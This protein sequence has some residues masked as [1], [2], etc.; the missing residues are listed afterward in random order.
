MRDYLY[1]W[2]EPDK[3]RLVASGIE[4]RDIVPEL[5]SADGVVLLRHK[6]ADADTDSASRFEFVSSQELTQLAAENIYDYGDFCWADFG[7]VIALA[8]LP[9]DA[10]AELT[11]FAHTARP[12][13][14]VTIPGL[15][16]R[17]LWYSHDDGWY[18][19]LFY[20]HWESVEGLLRRLLMGLLREE[21]AQLTLASLAR[22]PIAYWCCRDS[23]KVCEQSENIDALQSKYL[24]GM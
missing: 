4:F 17:F 23:V 3:K 1:L 16:N 20:D 8:D 6:F 24:T 2:H 9:D 21:Q 12:L 19:R 18:L 10:I 13:R 22:G 11:F 7:R 5:E 14:T 15:A